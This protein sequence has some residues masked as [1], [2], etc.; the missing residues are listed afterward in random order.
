M[1]VQSKVHRKAPLP[2]VGQKRNFINHF[3]KTLDEIIPNDGQG[4]TIVDAFGGSGLLAHVS[5]RFK[6]KATVI[7]NDFDDYHKRLLNIHE[8]NRLRRVVADILCDAP[9]NKKLSDTT[10]KAVIKALEGFDGVVDMHA[11]SSWLLFSGK[12]AGDLDAIKKMTLYNCI[13]RSDY[14]EASDYL[15]G[16]DVVK[17]DFETLLKPYLSGPKCLLVLDPPYVC[18][19]QG[20]YA[21]DEY[22]G[23]I[24][25]L[26]LMRLVRPPFVFFSSTRSELISYLNFVIEHR[27]DG[28]NRVENY[29]RI[30]V[31]SQLNATAKYEDNLVYKAGN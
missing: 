7:Y 26:R 11:V 28:Y 13:R 8:T 2:F 27:I 16:L 20:A 4:W 9:R 29:K 3:I 31:K 19:Q 24:E 23:M 1:Q 22:F 21:N 15:A 18:T 14:E 30:A 5:K 25:F 12:H 10:K 6:P 17:M